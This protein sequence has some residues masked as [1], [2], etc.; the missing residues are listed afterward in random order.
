MATARNQKEDYYQTLGVNRNSSQEEIK[1]AFRT[2][3]KQKHPDITKN[4]ADAEEF[5][6]ISEAYE[7]LSDPEKRQIY[8]NYGHEGINASQQ[9]GF[10]GFNS[11]AFNDI[12]DIF[13]DLFSDLFG[14]ASARGQQTGRGYNRNEPGPNYLKNIVISLADA[15]LGKKQTLN[16]NI[17]V[18][19]DACNQ[20]GAKTPQDYATCNQCQGKGIKIVTG[21]SIFGGSFRQQVLCNTCQ[22]TGKIILQKCLKCKGNRFFLENQKLEFN[23]PP[24]I[25]TGESL[26]IRGKGGISKFNGPQGDLIIRVSVKD[27]PYFVRKGHDLLIDVPVSYLDVLL[28]NAITIPTIDGL[29]LKQQLKPGMQNGDEIIIP[30]QGVIYG[31][32]HRGR[33]IAKINI[34]MPTKI[35]KGDRE[36]FWSINNDSKFVPNAEFI[37]KFNKKR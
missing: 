14:G 12:N 20:T 32:N 22:G 28:G 4:P 11:S 30:Q 33:L 3:A 37:D 35:S 26:R 23:I 1:R 6:K 18:P 29:L 17:E 16:L 27:D 5:K 9:G 25:S 2:L 8:D 21:N 31:K 34:K 10:G 24:S 36:K 19:C 15:V 13:G 7:V